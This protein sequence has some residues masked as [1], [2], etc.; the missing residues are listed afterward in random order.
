MC[1]MVLIWESLKQLSQTTLLRSLS[2]DPLVEALVLEVRSHLCS[3]PQEPDT[4][5]D[6]MRAYYASLDW[7]ALVVVDFELMLPVV[8]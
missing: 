1:I 6:T 8:P 7:I 2:L 5:V 4:S 3:E